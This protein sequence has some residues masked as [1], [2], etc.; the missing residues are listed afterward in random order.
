[1]QVSSLK[2]SDVKSFLYKDIRAE[3]KPNLG[4]IDYL[5]REIECGHYVP[6]IIVVREQDGY[7][8]ITGTHRVYT[9]LVLEKE[10]I[11][12]I[13]IEGTYESLEPVRKAEVLLKRYDEMTEYKYHFSAFQHL[14][15]A[16]VEK[17]DFNC[18]YSPD[19]YVAIYYRIRSVRDAIKSFIKRSTQILRGKYGRNQKSSF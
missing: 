10:Y 7:I 15:A 9:H 6:P 12:A 19:I 8:I 16:A 17:S 18:N 5:K 3:W 2:L 14:W 4:Y 11:N 1:M 13:I